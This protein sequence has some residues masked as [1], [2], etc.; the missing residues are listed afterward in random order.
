[1]SQT[2]RSN[3]YV[4]LT[5]DEFVRKLHKYYVKINIKNVTLSYNLKIICESIFF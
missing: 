5:Q 4:N 1:M 2:I 3:F